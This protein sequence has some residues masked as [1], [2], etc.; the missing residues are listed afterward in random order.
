MFV[1]QLGWYNV[2]IVACEGGYLDD[3]SLD[4]GMLYPHELRTG[5]L[6]L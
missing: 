1:E 2:E 3:Q 4:G 6:E 5:H